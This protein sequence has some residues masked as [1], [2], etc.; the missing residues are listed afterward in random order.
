MNIR[1]LIFLHIAALFVA[2][3]V[4]SLMGFPRNDSITL[5][6]GAVSGGLGVRAIAPRTRFVPIFVMGEDGRPA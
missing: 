1:P 4:Y 6:I 5:L 3:S 2:G